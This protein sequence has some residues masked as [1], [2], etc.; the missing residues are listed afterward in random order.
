MKFV[1]AFRLV[2]VGAVL[3]LGS[4]A[5]FAGGHAQNHHCKQADGTVDIKLT[6]KQCLA[7]KGTW[8]KDAPAAAAPAT[9]A[10]PAASATPAVPAEKK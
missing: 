8:A 2:T 4:G 1:K 6:K 10:A 7:A 3:A 9:P 5:V